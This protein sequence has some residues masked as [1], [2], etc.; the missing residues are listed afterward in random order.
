VR[1]R[2]RVLSDSEVPSFWKAF[3]EVGGNVGN[4]LKAILLTGQRPGEITA[5]RREHIADN[6]WTMPGE[7]VRSLGWPGTKNAQSHRVFLPTAV[8]DLIGD[9]GTTGFAFAGPR[10][11]PLYG[12]DVERSTSE[13]G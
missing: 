8:R 4:A 6:W 2:E 12:L 11:R 7:P 9:D 3:G 10:G 13:A 5:W 1:S